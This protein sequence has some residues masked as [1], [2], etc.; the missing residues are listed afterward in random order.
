MAILG[1]LFLLKRRNKHP[2]VKGTD[3]MQKGHQNC[4]LWVSCHQWERFETNRCMQTSCISIKQ[5]T[6]CVMCGRRGVYKNAFLFLYPA[7]WE[8]NS[9]A[10]LKA[11]VTYLYFACDSKLCFSDQ[12][13]LGL[14]VSLT[15]W[16]MN[17]TI[18]FLP[19]FFSFPLIY[20]W[21]CKSSSPWQ[22]H[23]TSFQYLLCSIYKIYSGDLIQY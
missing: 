12:G 21:G 18:L 10:L 2:I 9:W 7:S 5:K 4:L 13:S 19:L 8:I 6:L 14:H 16:Y 17:V 20:C 15:S 1:L 3:K 11:P 22:S 23:I